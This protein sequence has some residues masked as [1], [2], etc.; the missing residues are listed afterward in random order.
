MHTFALTMFDPIILLDFSK[1][2][3]DLPPGL[4]SLDT[5][6][7]DKPNYWRTPRNIGTDLFL[8]YLDYLGWEH[9]SKDMINTKSEVFEP[10]RF[11]IV[12][13]DDS[14]LSDVH[15]I[16]SSKE[17]WWSKHQWLILS[18]NHICPPHKDAKIDS[19]NK[20]ESN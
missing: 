2:S 10:Q 12:L 3:F 14:K 16:F 13:F 6:S 15:E 20:E 8:K 19:S 7:K 5:L 9:V 1:Q 11:V 4:P 18:Q 17:Q